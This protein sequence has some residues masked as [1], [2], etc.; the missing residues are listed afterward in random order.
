MRDGAARFRDYLLT[1]RANQ[2]PDF[3]FPTFVARIQAQAVLR[4][5]NQPE[6]STQNAL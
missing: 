2:G 5:L 1:I 3:I 4:I 6:K